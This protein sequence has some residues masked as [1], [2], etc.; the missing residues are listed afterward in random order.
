[1]RIEKV[2]A[3]NEI[4]LLEEKKLKG[5]G[6]LLSQHLGDGEAATVAVKL[7][8]IKTCGGVMSEQKNFK[9]PRLR[10]HTG[11]GY[12]ASP[13]RGGMIWRRMTEITTIN[14]SALCILLDE[15]AKIGGSGKTLWGPRN[16]Q[17]EIA[18]KPFHLS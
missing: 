6:G 10:E 12:S 2:G 11:R 3:G 8:K 18:S 13:L 17:N 14:P 16:G 15:G 7:G 9:I 5:G 4:G 1:M